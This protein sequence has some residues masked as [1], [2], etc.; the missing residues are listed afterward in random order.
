MSALRTLWCWLWHHHHATK[1]VVVDE[2]VSCSCNRC[3]RM[4][5]E[6]L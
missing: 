2:W 5:V 4:W 3:H 1:E 6:K